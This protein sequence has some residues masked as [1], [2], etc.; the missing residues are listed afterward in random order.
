MFGNN[1]NGIEIDLN[2][3]QRNKKNE[4][5]PKLR[6]K[7][8]VANKESLKSATKIWTKKCKR[9]TKIRSNL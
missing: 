3:H 9:M 1:V 6:K 5:D 8:R 4:L 7:K 2:D